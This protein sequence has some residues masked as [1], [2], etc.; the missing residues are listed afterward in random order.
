M[1]RD[2]RENRDKRGKRNKPQRRGY[3]ELIALGLA[4]NRNFTLGG[5]PSKAAK[6]CT[7]PAGPNHNQTAQLRAIGVSVRIASKTTKVLNVIRYC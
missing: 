7:T 3:N 2:G 4:V 5:K 1:K 6:R